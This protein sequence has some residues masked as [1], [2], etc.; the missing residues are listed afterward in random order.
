MLF[1]P[2]KKSYFLHG[3]YAILP[4]TAGVVP[5][6]LIMGTNAFNSGLTLFETMAYNIIVLSLIHI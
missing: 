2:I 6:G 1:M 5:F 4:L 3:V